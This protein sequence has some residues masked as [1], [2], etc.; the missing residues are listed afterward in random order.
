MS[1]SPKMTKSIQKIKTE[2]YSTIKYS[3]IIKNDLKF[4]KKNKIE[5]YKLRQ[6]FTFVQI[7]TLSILTW[8]KNR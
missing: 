6:V 2:L 3:E 7:K 4:K 1:L 8:N 5:L